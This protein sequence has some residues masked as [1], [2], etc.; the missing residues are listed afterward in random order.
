M[1]GTLTT[2]LKQS[3]VNTMHHI[4]LSDL[5]TNTTYMHAYHFVFI[6]AL[7]RE[8]QNYFIAEYLL[9]HMIPLVHHNFS[10][11]LYFTLLTAKI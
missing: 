5:I 3:L 6:T 2:I 4:F 1:L 7:Q 9:K 10:Y 11:H 8:S